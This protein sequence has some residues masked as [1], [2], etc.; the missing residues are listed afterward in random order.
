M[1]P[2]LADRLGLEPGDTF[3]L[4]TQDFTL[5]AILETEPDA[6]AD[7]FSLGPRTL[8]A[9]EALQDD[10]AFCS[11]HAVRD[12]VP[13]PP[14]PR[15]ATCKRLRGSRPKTRFPDSGLR[16]RDARNG[17]PGVAQFV[18]RLGAFLILVG[19]S[20]LAVGGIGVSAAVRAYLAGKT[21]VIATLRTLGA[22]R[23]T[24]FQTYFLQIGALSLLGIVIGLVPGR[25][26]ADPLRPADRRAL[27]VPAIFT[28]TPRR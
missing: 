23:A 28:I 3:R 1:A 6:A 20:G 10:R 21:S 2:L 8:V 17:A 22:T 12:R 15:A 25:A 11:R 24:I 9:T 14:A 18:D 7:G 13:P 5:S 19:L 27:P 4:G 26:C 16:W